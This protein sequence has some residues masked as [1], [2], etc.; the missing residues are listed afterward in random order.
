MADTLKPQVTLLVK[1]G[2]IAVH[3]DEFL[4]PG[5]HEFDHVALHLL[6]RDPEVVE[7]LAEMDRMAMVPKK[8]SVS[9]RKKR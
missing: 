5:G 6:L 3:A 4:S 7:W 1:L 9:K 2:S 8:R